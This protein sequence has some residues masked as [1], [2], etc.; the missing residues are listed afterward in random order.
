MSFRWWLFTVI[1]LFIVGV[2][3]CGDAPVSFS[4]HAAD[5]QSVSDLIVSLP[6]R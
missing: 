3:T 2:I 4:A 6:G 1:S 5:F